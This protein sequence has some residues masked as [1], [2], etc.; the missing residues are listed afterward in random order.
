MRIIITT[1]IIIVKRLV[2]LG[3]LTFNFDTGKTIFFLKKK[4]EFMLILCNNF[5]SKFYGRERGLSGV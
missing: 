2:L 4:K 3:L 5:N 1:I